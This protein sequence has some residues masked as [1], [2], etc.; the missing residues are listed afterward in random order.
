MQSIIHSTSKSH[1]NEAVSAAS[2]RPHR[3]SELSTP[4][5]V[6][7]RLC[8][9]TNWG[10]IQSFEIRDSEPVLS[11]PPVVLVDVKLDSDEESRTELDLTDFVL[12]DEICRLLDRF[13]QLKNVR[14]E[15][16][17]VRAG[18]PR[19]EMLWLRRWPD[20][21][22]GLGDGC[23]PIKEPRRSSPMDCWAF[24]GS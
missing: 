8:Q 3:F 20:R 21:A 12:R 22:R 23:S 7:V 1:R 19:R 14:I 24:R 11:P 5:Q 2:P 6:L 4:R 15:R 9:T 18:I 17:E 10:V 16:I 13:D